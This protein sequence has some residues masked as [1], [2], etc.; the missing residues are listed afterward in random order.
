MI[1]AIE[2]DVALSCQLQREGRR[3]IFGRESKSN[4]QSVLFNGRHLREFGRG[5]GPGTAEHISG[6]RC[7]FGKFY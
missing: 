6:D 5:L 3:I 4:H 7:Q 1:T 2:G